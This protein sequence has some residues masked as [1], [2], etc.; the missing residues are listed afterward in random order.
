MG[1]EMIKNGYK[2]KI[3]RHRTHI[4]TYENMQLQTTQPIKKDKPK[5]IKPSIPSQYK[6]FNYYNRMKQRRKALKELC[7]NNF[8]TTNVTMLTLTF[9]S[10][11]NTEKSFTDIQT[12]HYEFKKFIQRVNDHYDNFKY[13]ATFSRQTNG[14]WHY[15]VLCNFSHHMKNEEVGHLW[16]N[17]ITYITYVDT[18]SLFGTV[19]EY[20]IKNM[21]DVSGELNGKRG[22]LCAKSMERDIVITSWRAEHDKEFGEAFEKVSNSARKILYESKNHLGIRGKRINEETGEEF[23]VTIPDME[24]NPLLEQA[25]Y[26]SW[27]TVYTHLASHADFSDKFSPLVTATLKHKKFKRG[28]MDQ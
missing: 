8:D 6:D 27:D 19:V 10:T 25:G 4:T 22:Y 20:L 2:F 1:T 16:K 26:E 28:G 9:D 15:H 5:K 12:A 3:G 23:V 13:A 11:L 21:N 17:G 18:N 24:L 7:Y 14:N